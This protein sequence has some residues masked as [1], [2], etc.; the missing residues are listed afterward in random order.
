MDDFKGQEHL[1]NFVDENDN[2]KF[3]HMEAVVMGVR[4]R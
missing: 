2:E 3:G 4:R 1:F